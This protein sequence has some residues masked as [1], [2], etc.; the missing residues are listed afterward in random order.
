MILEY[1]F[2][3]NHYTAPLSRHSNG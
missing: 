1:A 3:R 2:T